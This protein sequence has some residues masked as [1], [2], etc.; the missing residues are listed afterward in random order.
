[1]W[2]EDVIFNQ[3]LL[4][5]GEFQTLDAFTSGSLPDLL[6]L[7]FIAATFFTQITMLN[8]LIAIMSDVF[9][10]ETEKAYVKMIQTKLQILAE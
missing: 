9:E 8:M 10:R 3:Y 2:L 4:S 1:M 5:L 7:V 6:V